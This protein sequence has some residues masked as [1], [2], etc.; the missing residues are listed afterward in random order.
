MHR[1][2]QHLEV[3]NFTLLLASCLSHVKDLA[4]D[5]ISELL[6]LLGTHLPLQR[7]AVSHSTEKICG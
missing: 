7:V 5:C 3:F 1:D 6:V 4:L 2:S